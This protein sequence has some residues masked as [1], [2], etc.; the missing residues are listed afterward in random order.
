MESIRFSGL[1]SGMDTQSIVDAM[2][3]AERMPLDRLNQ[4]KQVLE[5]QR[6]DY[7]SMNTL[8]KD[9]DTYLFDNIFRQSKMLKRTATS[10]NSD[11]VTATAS[12]SAGNVSYKIENVTLAT[13]ARR[14][15]TSISG[16]TKIDPSK[17]LWSQ[18]AN[19][20]NSGMSWKQDASF[21]MNN[22]T[23]PE[24]GGS[25]FQL[26]KGAISDISGVVTEGKITV[27]LSDGGTKEYS[28]ITGDIPKAVDRTDNNVYIDTNTGKMVFGGPALAKDSKFSVQFKQNYLEFDIKTFDENGKPQYKNF[29]F[30]GTTSLNSMFSKINQANTGVNLFYDSGTDKVVAM[31]TET[32]DF[33]QANGGFEMEFVNVTRDAN[34]KVTENTDPNRLN[35]F[36]NDVLGLNNS[37]E[38]SGSD[39]KFTINGLETTRKSNTFTMNDVT[40]T[41]KKNSS[42][43]TDSATINIKT[44]T[45]EIVKTI[46]EFVEKYNEMIGKINGKLNEERYKTFT[47]LSDEQKA[48]MKEKE[49]EQWEEKAKNGMLRRDSLLTSGLSKM[50]MDLY[51]EVKSTAATLT[52]NRYNQLSEIGI[53]TTKDYLDRGKLEIDEDKLRAAIEDNPEAVYQL[54]MAD[55]TSELNANDKNT[56]PVLGIAR[57]LRNTIAETM[58][59]VENKAGNTFKTEHNYSMGKD[60]L[61]IKDD[62][63][64]LQDRLQ[65]REKRYWNQFNAMEKA[66][67]QL[68]NQSSQLLAQ[69]GMNNK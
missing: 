43:S 21:T 54:F 27:N 63:T 37:T 45:D 57:R 32:G 44:D 10:S 33:N 65:Q 67:Q 38:T 25:E 7:R 36:F 13:A 16:G 64:R 30:D 52:D 24:K 48:G 40:F 49:I 23:V 11:F 2:M 12:A 35:T 60:L 56:T 3:K 4:K 1:A 39:A 28:V 55:G 26:T 8:L 62:I 58:Q 53:K 34:G 41:L 42:A 69:L 17:S 68:N 9:F 47:P 31:R 15:S 20:T 50:R 19:F 59:K 6:D 5:W 29:K 66:M 51:T 14:E 18:Q 61:R 22:F 46:K